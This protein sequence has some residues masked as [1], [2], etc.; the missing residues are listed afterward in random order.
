MRRSFLSLAAAMALCGTAAH[1]ELQPRANGMIYDT[2]MNITWIS[3]FNYAQTSGASADGRM[4]QD[5]AI[6]W[7][8]QLVYGGF[9][10]W[11]LPTA[12][13]ADSNCSHTV[14]P[15][16]GGAPLHVG[17]NCTGSEMGHLHYV[18]LGAQAN[19]E[20]ADGA[21]TA[22]LA[23]FTHIQRAD[24]SEGNG[25]YWTSSQPY[26]NNADF[27][28]VFWT[29]VGSQGYAIDTD[30]RWAVAV[31]DGDVLAVPEAPSLT[32]MGLGLAALLH[33]AR[34]QRAGVR[35]R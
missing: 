28:G 2:V 12:N 35:R 5:Q 29:F 22:N 33:A 27:G 31:R 11:R 10:D 15:I 7:A 3:D 23:L 17:Y 16:G 14:T 30:R 1:A 25:A 4:T 13:Y 24:P 26:A 6:A 18:D 34:R 19:G 9:D 21:N 32:M 20:M 8:S